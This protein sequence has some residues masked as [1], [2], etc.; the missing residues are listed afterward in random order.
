MI[1]TIFII[2]LLLPIITTSYIINQWKRGD[3]LLSRRNELSLYYNLYVTQDSSSSTCRICRTC[4]TYSTC[5]SSRSIYMSNDIDDNI[6]ST[7]IKWFNENNPSNNN[8]NIDNN[9]DDNDNS[10][11]ITIPIFPLIDGSC[12]PGSEIPLNIFVMKFRSLFNDIQDS[13]PKL[14]G[15]C[16]SKDDNKIV[17]IGTLCENLQQKLLPDG[18]QILSNICRQRFRVRKILQTEPYI[19]VEAEYPIL[20]KDIDIKDITELPISLCN[21]EN[22]VFQTLKDVLSLTNKLGE[23]QNLNGKS[24]EISDIVQRLSPQ[25]HLFRLQYATDFSFAICDS[26]GTSSNVRQLL[27]ETETVE[28]RLS[29]LK[30][31]L[32]AART[33][34]MDMVNELSDDDT[35]FN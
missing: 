2:L 31:L 34:L 12:F 1:S 9:I 25:S 6:F 27:L 10:N 5:R 22:E 3:S 18:R 14:F 35:A 23:L 30:K 13:N 28:K 21:L 26:L 32:R 19:I 4:T 16:M 20:D 11:I 15:V 24:I 8:N 17:E 7:S 29:I 33:T